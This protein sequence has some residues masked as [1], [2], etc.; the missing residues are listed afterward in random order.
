MMHFCGFLNHIKP[1]EDKKEFEECMHDVKELSMHQ[2]T[3]FL[4][5]VEWSCINCH[6]CHKKI[7]ELLA[8]A[9]PLGPDKN[10][11]V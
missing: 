1:I 10:P 9:G 4:R 2:A 5:I 8:N 3:Q 11:Y 7:T 6:S